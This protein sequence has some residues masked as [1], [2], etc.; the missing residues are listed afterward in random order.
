[1]ASSRVL[2]GN[3]YFMMAYAFRCLERIAPSAGAPQEFDHVHDLLAHVIAEEASRQ[4]RQGLNHDYATQR[5]ELRTVRGRIDVHA[6][7][8]RQTM[9]RGVVVCEYDEFLPDTA[10]NRAVKAVALMLA[11]HA[12]VE[13]VRRRALTRILPYFAQVAHIPVR[14]IDWEVLEL[15]RTN[16]S[17]RWLLGACELA[18]RGL[19]PGNEPGNASLPWQHTEAM[20]TLFENFVKEYFHVHHPELKPRSAHV[21]WD[22]RGQRDVGK[23]QLPAMRTDI[24][25]KSHTSTLIVDT[26]L[27]AQSMSYGQYGKATLHSGNL[28]QIH[29]YVH[30]AAAATHSPVGGLLLYARTDGPIQPELDVE[31]GGHRIGTTTVD[32]SSPWP[33][34]QASLE[35]VLDRFPDHGR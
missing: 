1:M 2:I 11:R 21:K 25:L 17:Y 3:V 27:Y 26:K 10:A 32:L 13:P 34:V 20:S 7:I 35:A 5:E 30:N 12:D 6:T 19:L 31:I 29:A 18:A 33:N 28:Y 14:A 15:H 22:L 24:T 9:Q 4:V 16:A 23:H 8:A